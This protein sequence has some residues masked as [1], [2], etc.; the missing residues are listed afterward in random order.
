MRL[1]LLLG[2]VALTFGT[3]RAD[4]NDL[5]LERM[6][7]PPGLPGTF[8]DPNNNMPLQSRYRSLLSELGVVM[9]P[10]F[11][12]PSDT[13]GYSGF[14]LSFDTTFTSISNKADFWK[15][16]VQD[17]SSSFLP[18]ITV[19]ARKGLWAPTPSF[20]L[21]AGGTYL[22][23]SNIFSLIAYAK[24]GIHE[25]FHK[26]PVPSIALRAAVSRLFGTSQVDLTVVSTD[27]S[28]SKSFG[29]G[30]TVKLDPYL[31][32][33]LLI[34]IARSQVIDT[35]PAVDAYRQGP[36]GVD[37]NSNTTFPTQDDILRWRLFLGM[38]LVYSLLAVS[39]E[40][41]ITFCNNAATD[42]APDDPSRIVDRSDH[43]HQLSLSIGL[44]Y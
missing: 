32:A 7:G 25:G 29:V 40:Y 1:P 16:G 35:T 27:L 34:M 6:V 8:N 11:L 23:D 30:G 12:S 20:E 5:T 38:R 37:L 42:C 3:A 26:L 19:M 33:N 18:T 36:M 9:A 28:V 39:A 21:G 2:L 44:I 14:H 10:I 43:Q 24:L 31:G 15:Q 17:V 13:L 4:R 41:A 22:V